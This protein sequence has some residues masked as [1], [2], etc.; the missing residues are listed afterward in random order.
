MN[1]AGFLVAFVQLMIAKP[2][3]KKIL[4]PI[5]LVTLTAFAILIAV[6]IHLE[7]NFSQVTPKE[8]YTMESPSKKG[9]SRFKM[10]YLVIHGELRV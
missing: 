10:G 8:S 6:D 9:K 3:S 2:T 7:F 1:A 4:L 5:V